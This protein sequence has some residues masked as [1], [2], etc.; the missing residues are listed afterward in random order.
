[1]IKSPILPYSVWNTKPQPLCSILD[2]PWALFPLCAGLVLVR[3]SFGLAVGA[4]AGLCCGTCR[5][6]RL[7]RGGLLSGEAPS[8]LTLCSVIVAPFGALAPE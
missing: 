8:L 4:C 7:G 2:F 1:M 5:A 3:A 6:G